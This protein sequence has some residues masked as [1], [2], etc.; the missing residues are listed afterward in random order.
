VAAPNELWSM[1]YKGWFRVGDGTRCDPLT[2]NDVHSRFSIDCR[3]L[4][5]PKL[6][7]VQSRLE[8]RFYEF[9]LPDGILSDNGPPFASTGIRRLSR[10]GVWLLRLGVRPVFIQPGRPDQNGRHERF[11]ATLKAETA[12][13]PKKTVSAQQAAFTRFQKIYNQERPHE[14]LDMLYPAEVYV[15][16]NRPMPDRLPEHVYPDVHDVRRVRRDGSMKWAGGM[17]FVGQAIAG[18][19][20][21][22]EAVDDDL[23]HVHLGLVRLGALHRGGRTVVPLQDDLDLPGVTHVPGHEEP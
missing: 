1:D 9:G 2:V 18:E 10:L 15:P 13:P 6:E 16:S 17:V 8:R 14:A 23:W 22:V 20:V 21:G 5:S 7:D 4:V 3:V 12:S 19:L 11:H